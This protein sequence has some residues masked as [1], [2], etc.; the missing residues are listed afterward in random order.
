MT[1]TVRQRP[2]WQ[3]WPNLITVVRFLLIP[4]FIGIS[5]GYLIMTIPLGIV[6]DR[7]ERR[8][9]TCATVRW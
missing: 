6:P 9:M 8:A 5:I 3:T 2:D 4:V 7:I 1:D